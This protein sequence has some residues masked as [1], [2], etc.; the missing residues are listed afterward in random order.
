MVDSSFKM[1]WTHDFK[2]LSALA[3]DGGFTALAIADRSG[4]GDGNGRMRSGAMRSWLAL[5]EARGLV[6]KMDDQKPICW[7][8]TP[9]GTAA[10]QQ[11]P[12]A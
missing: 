10:L 7:I 1:S 11:T 2:I 6:A 4:V 8:R 9:A 12:G 3:E 5:L